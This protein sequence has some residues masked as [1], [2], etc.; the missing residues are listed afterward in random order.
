MKR[1]PSLLIRIPPSPRTP[2]VIST[3]APATPVGWNC[4]NSM[5]CS[6]RPARA[7]MP[8]PSPVL[9]KALVEAAK[10][11]PAPPVAM[12]VV[13]A[14]RIMHSPVSISSATTPITSPSASRIRSSAIHS[15]KKC[16]R[17]SA[18]HRLFAEMG[19]VAAEWTLINGAIRVA[20][21][22]HAEVF[23]FVHDLRCF[24]AHEF[25]S[26]LVAQIVATL[27][28]VEHMPEP[29]VFG[30]VA[31]RRTDTALRRNC[32]RAGRENLGQDSDV[33]TGFSQLQRRAHA[34]TAG[35]N[36]H[37]IKA[38][39]RDCRFICCHDYTLQSI[40]TVQPAQA[41]N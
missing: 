13:F 6:G 39:G 30:H 1:S 23:Q 36:D 29:V 27:D 20:V 38:A 25:D 8:M 37:R 16:V 3:P 11:R 24:T 32:V 12:I 41:I 19:R 40:C 9:M 15:T 2:S 33:Q 14:S 7:A 17:A 22:W 35:A 34:G 10:I 4:Q 28:G 21:E 26:I 31:E 5:S 18:L